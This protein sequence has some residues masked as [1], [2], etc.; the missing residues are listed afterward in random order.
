MSSSVAS[1]ASSSG[2]GS[3][4]A[5][6]T[7][8]PGSATAVRA[9]ASLQKAGSS[10]YELLRELLWPDEE[11]S[12]LFK[13][14]AGAPPDPKAIFKSNDFYKMWSSCFEKNTLSE[15]DKQFL[16]ASA[17]TAQ[18]RGKIVID[19]RRRKRP[20]VEDDGFTKVA[21]KK[22]KR[23][24]EADESEDE[25][26]DTI[27]ADNIH[28]FE[29]VPRQITFAVAAAGKK[30]ARPKTQSEYLL[31]VFKSAD[32]RLPISREE[33]GQIEKSLTKSLKMSLLEESITEYPLVDWMAFGSEVGLVA[34]EDAR[35]MQV[36]KEMISKISLGGDV[37][38]GWEKEEL[39]ITL[40]VRLPASLRDVDEY[41]DDFIL[42]AM[43]KLNQVLQSAEHF[44]HAETLI[45]QPKESPNEFL[46]VD[47]RVFKF[48]VDYI[49]LDKIKNAGGKLHVVTAKVTVN[50]GREPLCQDK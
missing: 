21:G 20:N 43:R 7:P 10:K 19:F 22:R 16:F 35:S 38:R 33:F 2:S 13:R 45:V 42:V 28:D 44:S 48:K 4:A 9:S 36:L 8:I 14:L 18:S 1:E 50:K 15:K 31:H 40:S 23:S 46:P 30:K 6:L 47:Y 49:T 39:Y 17:I 32:E 34:A 26:D 3:A 5:E 11:K 27:T 37:F 25:E 41:P 29:M 24:P 12:E